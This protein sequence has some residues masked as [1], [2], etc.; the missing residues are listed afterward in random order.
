MLHLTFITQE[1]TTFKEK[2]VGFSVFPI[3]IDAI[4]KMPVLQEMSS[5]NKLNEIPRALHKG[6]Y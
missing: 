4:T 3:F 5:G 6:A 2:I 1:T